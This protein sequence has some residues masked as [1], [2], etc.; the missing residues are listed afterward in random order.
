MPNYVVK[1]DILDHIIEADGFWPD[2]RPRTVVEHHEGDVVDLADVEADRIQVFIDV[3]A[4]E[5]EGAA[6][7]RESSEESESEPANPAPR[8][9]QG[10]SK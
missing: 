9:A 3:G 2:G 5:E 7:E 8:K 6:K 10:A 4:I 1:A